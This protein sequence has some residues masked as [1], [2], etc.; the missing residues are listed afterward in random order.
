MPAITTTLSASE[1]FAHLLACAT[2]EL[3]EPTGLLVARIPDVPGAH[4]QAASAEEARS[5]LVE[6]LELLE[7]HHTLP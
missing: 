7:E 3:D 6:V 2:F 5:N 4:T 1:R